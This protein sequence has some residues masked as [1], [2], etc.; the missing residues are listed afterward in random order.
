ME[1][2]VHVLGPVRLER[3]RCCVQLS[4]QARVVLAALALRHGRP[5]SRQELA[6]ALWPG[7]APRSS[8][9]QVQGL[10][11]GLRRLLDCAGAC[12]PDCRIST[13]PAGYVL[14]P[15]PGELDL[16]RFEALATAGAAARIRG[17]AE[18]ARRYYGEALACWSGPPCADLDS[19]FVR[20][21]AEPLQQ[22]HADVLEEWAEAALLTGRTAGLTGQLAA[23]LTEHPFRER[24]RE[25]LMRSLA[26]AGRGAE[27]LGV[28]ERGRRLL[29]DQLGVDP[30]PQLQQLYLDLLSG[31]LDEARAASR[32]RITAGGASWRRPSA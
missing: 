5:V 1:L 4:G 30:S 23:A 32:E 28:Y 11:S 16:D 17:E 18:P 12:A 21:L 9:V 13:D 22:R 26:R 14:R 10:V 6:D 20:E 15:G 3:D 24:L 8:R 31:L 27:A 2:S 7:L 25:L 29:A 19:P